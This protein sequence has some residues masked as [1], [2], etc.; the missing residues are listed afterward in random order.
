MAGLNKLAELTARMQGQRIYPIPPH[1]PERG[2]FDKG[3]F[4]RPIAAGT[5]D[6]GFDRNVINPEGGM[7]SS[8]DHTMRRRPYE[9]I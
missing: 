7:Y 2:D 4:R 1:A 3:I 6:L 9:D 8:K 5:G